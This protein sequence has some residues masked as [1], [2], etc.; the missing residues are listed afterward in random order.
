VGW[1][2]LAGTM[3]TVAVAPRAARGPGAGKGHG[4]C[5]REGHHARA[6]QSAIHLLR[7][8]AILLDALGTLLALEPPAPRLRQVLADRFGLTLSSGQARDAIDAEIAYYRAHLG[9]GADAASLAD[10][11]ARCAEVLRGAL[12]ASDAMTAVSPQALT[13]ALLASLHFT[14]FPDAVPALAGAR[15][16]GQR[17]VVLSNWDASLSGVLEAAG[18]APLLDGIVCS[19]VAG[20]RKPSPAIFE[21]ALGVAG[22]T[23]RH[24]I[25]VGDS[26]EEDV[27]GARGACI[28][29]VLIRRDRSSGPPG[30][31][32]IATL[33]ELR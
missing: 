26:I 24:A 18:L 7:P 29:P 23:A 13:G 30:V 28:E 22:V 21:Q 27:Q 25:H 17:L 16:R 31:R 15:A 6:V 8:G 12:P 3:T 14:A 1:G 2:G 9:E 10:L 11:R 4:Q 5:S 20:A 32:T 19:A 33:A